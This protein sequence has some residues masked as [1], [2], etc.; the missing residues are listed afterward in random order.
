MS[1]VEVCQK[2]GQYHG[3]ICGDCYDELKE[4]NARLR[5]ALN[6]VQALTFSWVMTKDNA[7]DILLVVKPIRDFVKKTLEVACESGG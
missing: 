5:A 6:N 3:E 4:E 1:Y 2:H 7:T